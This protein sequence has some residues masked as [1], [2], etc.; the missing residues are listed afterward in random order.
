[1]NADEH[2]STSMIKINLEDHRSG[3]N[4]NPFIH[5]EEHEGNEEKIKK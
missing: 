3:R 4:E 5:H 1:V 2:G